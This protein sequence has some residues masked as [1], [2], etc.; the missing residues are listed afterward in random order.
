MAF[1][2]SPRT[3]SRGVVFNF[4]PINKK[5]YGG[6]GTEAASSIG[7]ATGTLTNGITYNGTAL[8]FD[9]SDEQVQFNDYLNGTFTS[10]VFTVS[11]WHNP[12]NVSTNYNYIFTNGYPVQ[13][14]LVNNK[15]KCWLS[16]ANSGGGNYFV[17]A[18][19]ANTGLSTDTWYNHVFVNR[20][21]DDREWFLNGV[22]DGTNTGNGTPGNSNHAAGG[23][24][25][26]DWAT[27]G[28]D[29]NGQISQITVHNQALTAEEILRNYNAM[30][31]RYE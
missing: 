7:S 15:M 10:N 17:S 1:H 29:Y 18:F 30:K 5:C 14:T 12:T 8:E 20:A 22:S 2:H 24:R 11:I 31:G 3:V 21:A 25:I 16:S 4:D 9:G 28:L 6:S 26:G 27:S 19:E 23:V 13:F